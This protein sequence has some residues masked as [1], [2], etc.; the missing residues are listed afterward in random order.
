MLK[1]RLFI[2]TLFIA[3]NSYSQITRGKVYADNR[4]KEGVL[5]INT[6][7]NTMSSTNVKGDFSFAANL[8]DSLV[9]SASFYKTQLI[10]VEHYHLEKIWVVELLENR[11]DLDEVHLTG[12]SK[13]KAFSIEE[14][15]KNFNTWLQKDI[16]EN[17]FAYSPQP[18]GGLDLLAIGKMIFNGINRT[19]EKEA[20]DAKRFRTLELEELI[21]FFKRDDFFNED[22]LRNQLAI[23]KSEEGTYFD[24]CQSQQIDSRLLL[25]K[26]QIRFLDYLL[27]RSDEYHNLSQ[28]ETN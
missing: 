15:D 21:V 26:N 1:T 6:T 18:S 28:A 4:P 13:I 22:L 23:S 25:K 10:K 27:K 5:I 14:Y 20:L 16:K 7:Q 9:F 3:L 8:G 24:Y 19:K 2:L 12:A 11:N 17:P